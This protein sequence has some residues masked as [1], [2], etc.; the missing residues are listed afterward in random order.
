MRCVVLNNHPLLPFERNRYYIGKLLTSADFQAEQ[1]Y[2]ISKRK[3][4]NELMFGD[5]IVC[6]LGVYSLDDQSVMIDSGIAL[7][8]FGR[9]IIVDSTVVRK[10]SAVEGFDQLESGKVML[11][12]R[13]R[14]EDVHPVYAV[15]NQDGGENYECNRVREGFSLFL[16]DSDS[17]QQAMLPESDFFSSVLFFEDSEYSITFTMPAYAP[18]GE[19]VRLDLLVEGHSDEALP[20][21]FETVLQTP[22]FLS[23]EG[24]HELSIQIQQLRLRAGERMTRSFWL[25]AQ[26]APA[27]DS[28]LLAGVESTR[29]TVGDR[30][31]V[32][33]ENFMMRVSVESHSAYDLVSRAIGRISLETRAMAGALDFVPLCEVSLQRT[34]NAYLIEKIVEDGVKRYVQT[35]ATADMRRDFQSYYEGPKTTIA[36]PQEESTDSAEENSSRYAEPVY[37][38]GVCEIPIGGARRGQIIQSDEILHGLG[39]GNVLVEVAFEYL[40]DDIRLGTQSRNTIFGD[41]SLFAEGE[42]LPLTFASTAVKVHNDRGSF[43]V[44]AKLEQDAIQAVLLLR[45]LAVKMPLGDESSRIQRLAGKSIAAEQPT[46]V[47]ATRES[48]YFNIRFKNMEPCTLSYELTESDSGTITTDGIY[49]APGKEGVYEIR[50][51]CAD[52][53]LISTYAYAV[54]KKRSAEQEEERAKTE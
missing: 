43:L 9:E 27:Q 28:V 54:V 15:S 16:A 50:I 1:M 2:G 37:A 23:D 49:T 46:V 25:S 51:S 39:R 11:C 19:Q 33:G 40:A 36:A 21:S 29:V 18:C 6:G 12:L 30:V 7:D 14:E 10:L 22:A 53:P 34:K 31:E 24:E 35:T 26:N 8:G 20:L 32:L 42:T 5:G 41:A 47:L 45:W 52:T 17:L 3:F 13:Y 4:L 48:H 44:A 38:T